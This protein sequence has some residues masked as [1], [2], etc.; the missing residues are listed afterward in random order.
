LYFP[1][2]LLILSIF[3]NYAVI[4]AKPS[5]CYRQSHFQWIKGVALDVFIFFITALECF[6]SWRMH[7]FVYQKCA[8]KEIASCKK[9]YFLRLILL[10][11]NTDVST[12]KM[13]LDISILAKSIMSQRE[14][15]KAAY[16]DPKWSN[17]SP[18]PCKAGASCS[19]CPL[20]KSVYIDYAVKC[21]CASIYSCVLIESLRNV[22]QI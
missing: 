3:F 15:E 9:L 4:F 20:I 17:P 7:I 21:E 1:S 2:F 11:A 5:P 22:T 12:T 14:Y 10:F 16:E 6:D 8:Y 13:C 19:G 18:D